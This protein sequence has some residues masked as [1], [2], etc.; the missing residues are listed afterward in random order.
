M[1][2]GTTL[3]KRRKDKRKNELK[4]SLSGT[5]RSYTEIQTLA[6]NRDMCREVWSGAKLRREFTTTPSRG[7][8]DNND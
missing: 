2:R 3:G 8:D 6:R 1:I 4:T 7:T 5:E